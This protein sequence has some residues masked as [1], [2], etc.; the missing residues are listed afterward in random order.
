[1]QTYK[2][3]SLWPHCQTCKAFREATNS[4]GS[5]SERPDKLNDPNEVLLKSFCVTAVIARGDASCRVKCMRACALRFEKGAGDQACVAACPGSQIDYMTTFD[6]GNSFLE[7]HFRQRCA[8]SRD[9]IFIN[10]RTKS[11]GMGENRRCQ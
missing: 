2:T 8:H 11:L 3:L 9:Y 6:L 1:M 10:V 4:T 5:S 7:S